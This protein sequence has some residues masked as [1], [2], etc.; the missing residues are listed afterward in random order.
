MKRIFVSVHVISAMVITLLCGGCAS[1]PCG[2]K[3]P[4]TPQKPIIKVKKDT[5]GINSLPVGAY[6]IPESDFIVL[7][8]NPNTA[9]GNFGLV[10][11]F[12]THVLKS[13][14]RQSEIGDTASNYKIDFPAQVRKELESQLSEVNS[15]ECSVNNSERKQIVMTLIP[16]ANIWVHRDNSAHIEMILEAHLESA[17]GEEIWRNTFGYVSN[18]VLPLAGPMGWGNND[19]SLSNFVTHANKANIKSLINSFNGSKKGELVSVNLNRDFFAISRIPD[20]KATLISESNSRLILEY[21]NKNHAN[22][23]YNLPA[24]AATISKTK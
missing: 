18:D 12:V 1:I 10:G 16:Y 14:A 17:T 22:G 15:V 20:I 2:G 7:D 13:K 19:S 21:Q 8:P 9:A 6:R 23:V 4:K 24:K 11:I 3:L 5:R